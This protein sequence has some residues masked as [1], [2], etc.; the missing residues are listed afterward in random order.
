MVV[1]CRSLCVVRCLLFVDVV[2]V[3]CSSFVVCCY[4]LYVVAWCLLVFGV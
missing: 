1:D 4:V 2:H 3:R